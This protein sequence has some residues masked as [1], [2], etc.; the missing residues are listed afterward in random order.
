MKKLYEGT[1]AATSRAFT[2]IELLV[3]IAII[4]ILSSVVLA[5]LSSSRLKARDAVVLSELT[6]F[7]NLAEMQYL[8]TG[9]YAG[10]QRGWVPNNNTCANLYTVGNY[11]AQALALC[12]AIVAQ[13]PAGTISMFYSGVNGLSFNY[14]DDYSFMALMPSSGYYACV[15]SSGKSVGPW[16]NWN[17]PG[18]FNNP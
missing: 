13:H 7:A 3:V 18:C 17:S 14:Q 11:A 5:S 6:Q 10:L 8:D 12:N 9:S 1:I 4:G 15:G 16:N 2:L